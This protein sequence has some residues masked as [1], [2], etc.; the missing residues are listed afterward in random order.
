MQIGIRLI[1]G[2]LLL[3]SLLTGIATTREGGGK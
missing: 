2:E 3:D 1:Q